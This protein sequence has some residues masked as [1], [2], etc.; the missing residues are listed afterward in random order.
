MDAKSI[1]LLNHPPYSKNMRHMLGPAFHAFQTELLYSFVIVL[2]SLIIYFSTKELYDLTKHKGIKFFRL[3][4]LFFALAYLTRSAIKFLLMQFDKKTIFILFNSQL[5]KIIGV[6]TLTLFIYLSTMAVLC[7]VYSL[8]WKR[9]QNEKAQYLLH[10]IAIIVALFTSLS[11]NHLLPYLAINI[12]LFSSAILAILFCKNKS[13]NK[14][15]A[16]YVLLLAFWFLNILD[17]LVPNF[18]INFQL[19]IYLS[20]VALFIAMLF[21]VTKHIGNS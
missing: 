9:Y 14:L 8:I 4:F 1:T 7:L 11:H 20:S 18:F 6:A 16:I 15:R 13:K 5:G 21:K 3:T 17:I 2:V 19:W 12:L 10:A